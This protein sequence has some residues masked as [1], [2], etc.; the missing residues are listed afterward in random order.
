MGPHSTPRGLRVLAIG[1]VYRPNYIVTLAAFQTILTRHGGISVLL[2]LA[3]SRHSAST[4]GLH[5]RG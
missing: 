1:C 5:R 2:A 3:L 4:V